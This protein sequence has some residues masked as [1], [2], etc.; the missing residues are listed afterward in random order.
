MPAERR[1][2]AVSWCDPQVIYGAHRTMSSLELF[3]AMQA[4]ELPMEPAMALV[5]AELERVEEGDVVFA[6]VVGERHLDHTGCLHGGILG[7]LVDTAAGYAVHTKLP[8]GV[9]CASVEFH[10][11]I[12]EPITPASGRIRIAGRVGHVGRRTAACEA[13]VRDQ[14]GALKALMGMTMIVLPAESV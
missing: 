11:N 8:V 1:H 14:A 7:A 4:G 6:L 13:E 10:L 9:R 2:A 3:R 5:G 12:V